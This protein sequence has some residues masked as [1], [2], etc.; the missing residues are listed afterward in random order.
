MNRYPKKVAL[1][2]D[3]FFRSL[4]SKEL[5]KATVWFT[6]PGHFSVNFNSGYR[7]KCG[8]QSESENVALD[9]SVYGA[10]IYDGD[11]DYLDSLL[12]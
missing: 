12:K 3:N 7:T 2:V 1:V 4:I 5:K 10:R 6:L 11:D 8:N 9:K